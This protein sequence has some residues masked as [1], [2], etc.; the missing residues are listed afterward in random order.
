M[1]PS[2]DHGTTM[3]MMTTGTMIGGLPATMPVW[4][5]AGH[6]DDHAHA[7]QTPQPTPDAR[8]RGH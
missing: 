6:A 5:S 7:T 8:R 2:R 4:R 1:V 3:E